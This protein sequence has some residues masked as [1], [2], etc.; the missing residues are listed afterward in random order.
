MDS[1]VIG[2]LAG[3]FLWAVDTV[4]NTVERKQ[5]QRLPSWKRLVIRCF[6]GSAVILLGVILFLIALANV[7]FIATP[8]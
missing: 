5:R 2:F 1:A 8:G 6:I 7:H 3:S 4:I